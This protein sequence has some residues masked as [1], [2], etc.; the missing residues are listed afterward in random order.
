MA[1]LAIPVALVG[2]AILA[3]AVPSRA[4]AAAA[5]E[6]VTVTE[7]MPLGEAFE[8]G[9]LARDVQMAPDGRSAILYDLTLVEDDGPGAC[10]DFQYGVAAPTAIRGDVQVKK[11]LRVDRAEV[12]DARVV[13]SVRPQP[14]ETAPLAVAVNGRD[15]T[16]EVAQF[17]A[18]ENDW[19]TVR[20]PAG[21]LNQADNEIVLSCRGQKG[22]LITVAQRQFILANGPERKD[23]PNR[24]FRS[25]DGGRTWSPGLGDDGRQDGE[26]MVRLNLAQYAAQGELIGPIIDLAARAGGKDLASDV[27][28]KSLRLRSTGDVR[29]G[30]SIRFSVRSGDKPVYDPARWGEW[31]PCDASGDV[32]GDLKR[33]VQWRAVLATSK[34]KTT[35]VLQSVELQ[36]QVQPQPPAWAAKL[37]VLDAHNEEILYTSMPFEY[38]KFDEPALVELRTKY[39]L[40]EVVAGASSETDKMIKLRN[41]VAAQ[42]KYDPPIPY[43]PAWDAREILKLHKGFCVQFAIANMQCALSL[44]MQARFVFGHFPNVRLKGRIVSGHEVTEVWSNELGKWVMMDAQRN[45]SFVSRK[46]GLLTSM[47]ELHEDQLDTY[48]PKGVDVR[49]ASFDE[50]VPSEGLLWWQGA[51][52]TTRS[53]KPKLEIKWGYV[54]WV[55]RNN[56]Y[57]HR[58]PEPLHQGLTW[59]WTGYWNLEDARTPRLS[60]YGRYT[61]RRSDIEWTLNQVRWAATPAEQPGKIHLVMGTVTPDFDTFLVST[62]G[63]EWRPSADT[64]NWPLHAG[65]NRM[66]MRIRT[67]AG[68]LGRK[69]WLEVESP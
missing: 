25:T 42:W 46:T 7:A 57:A 48:F 38:E 69:S 36:A 62:D 68:V 66:E 60:R 1:H 64:L 9:F 10:A 23:R 15:L 53:E 41:W 34:P 52:P 31:L 16:L 65:K 67:R 11:V 18:T 12:L 22:W 33:F 43:Y 45:E 30:T 28:V 19:P 50:E 59:S 26:L 29:D 17:K 13:L 51:E 24:S 56:F 21:L 6:A 20:I 55:P 32:R 4:M 58:F 40:D 8:K 2:L 63:G 14:E 5:A 3:A 49:G 54:Q 27:Q 39:K 44:G 35:P 37:K 47:W 61:H